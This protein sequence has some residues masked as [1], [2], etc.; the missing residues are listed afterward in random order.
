MSQEDAETMWRKCVSKV[1]SGPNII[2]SCFCV[3]SQ[4]ATAS[5][6]TH[7]RSLR[8]RNEL[9]LEQT[10][11]LPG[12]RVLLLSLL[13]L[14]IKNKQTMA[15]LERWFSHTK[16]RLPNKTLRTNNVFL[17]VLWPQTVYRLVTARC[18]QQGT[19]HQ[20]IDRVV[21]RSMKYL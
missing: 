8:G 12:W 3:K 2:L 20:S 4:G 13:L 15:G 11:S 16:A 7:C 1:S 17:G 21:R 18:H 9:R 14:F 10:G 6:E 19:L 5:Q